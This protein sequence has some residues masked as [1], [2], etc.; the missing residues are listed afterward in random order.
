MQALTAGLRRQLRRSGRER[1]VVAVV[2]ALLMGVFLALCAFA[3]DVGHWYAVGLQEQ[4]AADAAALAGVT[5]LPGDPNGAFATAKAFASRNGYT[6][7]V[8]T[9][10]V[11][12]A[13]G[14]QPSRLKVD[15]TRTVPNV[16]GR[17]MG[18]PTT[19]ITRTA[20]ADYV[21]PVPMGSPC[22]EFGND[23]TPGSNRSA[24]CDNTGQFWANVGTKSSWKTLGDA[25]QD[26]VCNGADGC[27][28]A[29]NN[30]YDPNGYFYSITLSQGMRNLTVEAFDP[31][32]VAVGDLCEKN[33]LSDPSGLYAP[34]A[35]S[36][37]CTGDV[38]FDYPTGSNVGT[39]TTE[40]TVRQAVAT[41]NPWDPTSYPVVGGCTTVFPGYNESLAGISTPG[42]A[43]TALKSVF[44]Q[45]KTLCSIPNAPAGT[46]FVQVK[47]NGLGTDAAQGHNRFALRAYSSTAATGKDKI[48][49]SG[50]QKMG[51]YANLPGAS[52]TFHLAR[53]PSSA[54]GHVLNVS[55]FDIGDST[56]VG[57]V[58]VSAPNTTLTGCTG[59]GP[60]SGLLPG[61]SILASPLYNGKWETIAVPVPSSYSCNDADPTACWFKLN[62]SYGLG[63]Q[64][65]DTTSWTASLEGDPVRL[66]Q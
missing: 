41:S 18:R 20:V 22:N 1:G 9:V 56:G 5:S 42:F 25:Y 52:T 35:S 12:P 23:P 4:R 2:T 51:I 31:A 14:S 61:C 39:V 33:G 30:N 46:Y 60:T 48:S 21:G 53:I 45:W 7:G 15:V 19:T 8:G 38:A 3:I 34:G 29:V 50:F 27:S 64:P 62:Y 17:I 58:T 13:L 55:L 66:V 36:P 54:A 47:T 24:N 16:F 28:G 6:D 40:F 44:R 57:T 43:N 63:N 10:V 26:G 65:S 49:L 11:A 37:Y 32:F 59:T